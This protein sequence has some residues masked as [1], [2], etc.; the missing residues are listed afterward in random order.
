[1]GFCWLMA[2]LSRSPARIASVRLPSESLGA[3]AQLSAPGRAARPLRHLATPCGWP[4]SR[5]AAGSAGRS[6]VTCRRWSC[7]ERRRADGTARPPCP[8]DSLVIQEIGKAARHNM[9][10]AGVTRLLW[11]AGDPLNWIAPRRASRTGASRSAPSHRR[12]A[13]QP[14]A[15]VVIVITIAPY[16][17]ARAIL[18]RI[19][20]EHKQAHPWRGVPHH[21]KY[22]V[23][24]ASTAS[25]W[26][27]GRITA[28]GHFARCDEPGTPRMPNSVRPW[29]PRRTSALAC[30]TAG[31][32]A[33]PAL[34]S[35]YRL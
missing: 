34:P 22:L 10:E 6:T 25:R 3:L 28:N 8:A 18:L 19:H 35:S 11:R 7:V 13:P 5:S 20:R 30:R 17:V 21:Q 4:R 29:R 32:R 1:M 31:M 2:P 24:C 16:P 9:G 27:A 26:P 33:F 14:P 15:G 23:P 12:C